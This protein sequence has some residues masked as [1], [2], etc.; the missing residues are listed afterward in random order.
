MNICIIGSGN[1]ATHFAKKLQQAG[2]HITAIY[3]PHQ[4]HAQ[5]LAEKVNCPL[6]TNQLQKLPKAAVIIFAITDKALAQTAQEL[7]HLNPE[8]HHAIWVHTAGCMP[9]NTL[10]AQVAK[11][12]I[13]PLM[14]I[15]KEWEN[16][17]P[18]LPLF[19]E[20]DNEQTLKNICAIAQQI[21]NQVTPLSS[22][23]RQTLHLAAVFANNFTNHCCAIAYQLLEQAHI[24]PHNLLPIITQTTQ[25]LQHLTPQQAQTGPAVRNDLNVIDKHLNLLNN[26]PQLQAIYQLMSQSIGQLQQTHNHEKPQ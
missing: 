6:A 8:S 26:Q 22:N 14:T 15:T 24:N 2:N 12:V 18:N 5:T 7:L 10:P 4:N 17:H 13:Y 23:Q 1:V 3:S 16:T 25:K 11:G 19:I 20:A 21:S 9:L